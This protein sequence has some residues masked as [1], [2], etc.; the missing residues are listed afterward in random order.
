MAHLT[1]FINEIKSIE[2]VRGELITT[3]RLC[4]NDFLSNAFSE[5]IY[6]CLDENVDWDVA[7]YLNDKGCKLTYEEINS[8]SSDDLKQKYSEIENCKPNEYQFLYHTYMIV[9]AYLEG[10][11]PGHLLHYFLELINSQEFL[12]IMRQIT[13][14]KEIIKMDAQATYYAKGNFLKEHNDADTVQGRRYAYVLNMSKNWIPDW[15]GLL[16]FTKENKVIESYA[17]SYNSL[18][19]FE[20]P[21]T[22]FVS[23]VTTYAGENRLA[24]T[25]WMYD[26]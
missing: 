3:S 12:S 1:K 17:P 8:A 18:V 15:G 25:G 23:Q 13:G 19:I 26:Q 24:I 22:H 20:V 2:K 14:C 5:E 21:Q 9:T 6:N 11:N 10:K 4:I 7:Y 16:H